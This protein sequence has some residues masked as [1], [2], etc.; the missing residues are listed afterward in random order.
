MNKGKWTQD[1]HKAYMTEWEKYGNNWIEVA[2]IVNTRTPMQIKKH[3]ECHLKQKLKT[4]APTVQQ[5]QE[6][7]PFEKKARLLNTDAA[8]HRKNQDFLSPKQKTHKLRINVKEQQKHRESL[9]PEEKAAHQTQHHQHLT[10]E[11]KEID[12]WIKSVAATLY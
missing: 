6:S 7:I 12:A 5:Y 10:E 1:E 11:E 2:K 9:P 8:A 3:A 4:N